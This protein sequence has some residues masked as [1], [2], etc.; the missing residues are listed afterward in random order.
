MPPAAAAAALASLRL[1]EAEPERVA[2]LQQRARL[3]LALAQAARA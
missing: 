2:R 1:L 3:F